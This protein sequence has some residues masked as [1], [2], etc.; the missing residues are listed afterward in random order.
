MA[1]FP[2]PSQFQDPSR[3]AVAFAPPGQDQSV[4]G[5]SWKTLRDGRWTYEHTQL[6]LE[7]GDER[8]LAKWAPGPAWTAVDHPQIRE[9]LAQTV[10]AQVAL[11]WALGEGPALAFTDSGWVAVDAGSAVRV[12]RL[13]ELGVAGQYTQA[14]A[15]SRGWVLT[16]ETSFRGFAGAAGLVYIPRPVLAP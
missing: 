6:N 2:I 15:L 11:G 3:Q 1:P 9:R 13:P 5:V 10:G 14:V 12:Y 8:P 4:L 16:W 7:G